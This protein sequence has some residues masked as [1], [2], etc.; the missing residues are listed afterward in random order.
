MKKSENGPAPGTWAKHGVHTYE[1]VGTVTHN[2][3][4]FVRYR[5]RGQGIVHRMALSAW[6]AIWS[7]ATERGL[8]Q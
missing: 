4:P 1:V 5:L 2:R 8:P 6:R 3:V 7:Q